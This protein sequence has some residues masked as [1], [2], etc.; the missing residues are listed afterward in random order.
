MPESAPQ[1][2]EGQD[3]EHECARLRDGVVGTTA[4]FQRVEKKLQIG[5]VEFAIAVDVAEKLNLRRGDISVRRFICAKVGYACIMGIMS[6][7]ST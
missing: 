3:G 4:I 6:R 1:H 5:I 2:T 7:A